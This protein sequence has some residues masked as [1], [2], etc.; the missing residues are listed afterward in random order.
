MGANNISVLDT[1]ITDRVAYLNAASLG[2]PVHRV[3][4]RQ[5]RERRSPSAPE[6]M[7]ALAKELFPEWREAI[8]TVGRCAELNETNHQ[9]G[10]SRHLTFYRPCCQQRLARSPLMLDQLPI[11]VQPSVRPH[12]PPSEEY[13]TVVFR[14]QGGR[15][16][17]GWLL[18]ELSRHFEGADTAEIVKFAVGDHLCNQH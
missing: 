13:C 15:S 9:V 5:S 17:I 16:A 6:T 1:V 14:M 2:L 10:I 4:M 12:H 3:E 7:Q 18:A 8:S 11:I